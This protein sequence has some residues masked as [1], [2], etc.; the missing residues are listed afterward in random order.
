MNFSCS[1][2]DNTNDTK[3]GWVE[4]TQRNF[5]KSLTRDKGLIG[6][7]Y[8]RVIDFTRSLFIVCYVIYN[9]RISYSFY[10]ELSAMKP[11]LLLSTGIHGTQSDVEITKAV[12]RDS[13][14][15]NLTC[16][17]KLFS[18]TNFTYKW[19]LRK[20]QCCNHFT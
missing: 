4:S 1:F 3:F 15:M 6:H 10:N 18:G 2:K 12:I 8:S 7:R 5:P 20:K 9:G 13:D 14:K 11:W 16:S 19:L 17:Y